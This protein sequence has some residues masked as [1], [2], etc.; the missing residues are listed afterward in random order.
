M[1]TSIH[2]IPVP[3]LIVAADA[4]IQAVNLAFAEL[5]GAPMDSLV[6][7]AF[8]DLAQETEATRRI[9]SRGGSGATV[10]LEWG[11]KTVLA[12]I[13]G[14]RVHD[15]DENR[16]TILCL[17]AEEA[18][19]GDDARRF[20]ELLLELSRGRTVDSG[21]IE[22][23]FGAITEV[24]SRGLGTARSSI[25]LYGPGDESIVC[26][27]LFEAGAVAHSSG[28]ELL[29][30]DY[31]KYFEALATDRTIAADDART[32][33]ATREFR[34]G[35]L[36]PLGI[37]SML[38]APIRRGGKLIGVLCNEHIGPARAFTSEERVFSASLADYVARAMDAS[39][40]RSAELALQRANDELAAHSAGLEQLVEE[41]TRALSAK[42]AENQDLIRRLRGALEELSTPV[43]E[44]W[45][46]VLALPVVGVLDS[47]RSAEMTERL[48]AETARSQAKVVIVDLTGVEV[49]DTA[50]ADR[51][52]KLAQAVEMLGSR[53]IVTGIQPAVAQTIVD[54]GVEFGRLR[55][56][57]NLKH[58]L[59][60]SM[61]I[62][63][64]RAEA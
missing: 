19:Q 27:D 41:R 1:T 39:D 29:A 37:T 43:L 47:Q 46:D 38:E 51:L 54:L 9:L 17:T 61:K 31:P 58:A 56:L 15:V 45:D 63:S 26:R 24:A 23:S 40:R 13:V 11:E 42:D 5:V 2:D 50:T 35:Y 28:L 62:S 18:G 64:D 25:W 4:T 20:G 30:R 10:A 21:A 48:L 59:K 32:H 14:S 60:I 34:D 36:V 3:S 52:I 49:V 12:R 57:R 44:L 8:S 55:T 22:E 7:I 16:S 53:C 6:G 33:P